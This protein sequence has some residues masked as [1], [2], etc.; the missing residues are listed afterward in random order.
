MHSP[1]EVKG[2]FPVGILGGGVPPDSL[3]PDPV[4]N[5]KTP[6][7]HPLSDLHGQKLCHHYLDLNTKEILKS[8]SNSHITLSFL[9]IW[10]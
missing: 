4:S 10:N 3:N 9:F 7:S 6:F 1:D 8:I 2:L 5:Q